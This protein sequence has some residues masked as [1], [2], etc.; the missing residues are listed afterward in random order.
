MYAAVEEVV[1]PVSFD[2]PNIFWGAVF[3]IVMLVVMYSVCL[4]PIRKAMADRL[5]QQRL[6]EESAEKAARDAEQIRRDYDATIA[7]ARADAARIIHEARAAADAE[8]HE[9]VSVVETE[10]ATARQAVMAELDAQRTAA[11]GSMLG[12]VAGIATDAASKVV[13]QRLDTAAQQSIVDEFVASA[14]RR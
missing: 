11:L 2:W 9:R 3:F 4:P 12:T 5:D 14:T 1:N 13:Q 7:D 10:L 8:R 6:D